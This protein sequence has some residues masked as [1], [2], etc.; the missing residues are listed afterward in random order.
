[1]NSMSRFFFPGRIGFMYYRHWV[2]SSDNE[3]VKLTPAA[4]GET[5][6]LDWAM[7]QF[8]LSYTLPFGQGASWEINPKCFVSPQEGAYKIQCFLKYSPNY[9]WRFDLGAMWQGGSSRRA[10]LPS[11][12]SYRWNDEMYFR[13]TYSF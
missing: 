10:F 2:D 3:D 5:N 6:R 4:Y 12:N 11:G 13:V 7:D 8:Y 1:M 9:D